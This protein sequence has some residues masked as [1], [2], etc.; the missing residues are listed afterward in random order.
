MDGADQLG[1]ALAPRLFSHSRIDRPAGWLPDFSADAVDRYRRDLVSAFKR[2]QDSGVLEIITC[3]ATHGFLPLM[4]HPEAVR[5]QIQ[6][7]CAHYRMHF[8]RDPR[9]VRARGKA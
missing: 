3:G 1:P 5:A 8:G 4:V 9:G 6:V 7:A 2:L